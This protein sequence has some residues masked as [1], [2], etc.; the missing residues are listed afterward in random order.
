MISASTARV[1]LYGSKKNQEFLKKLAKKAGVSQSKVMDSLLTQLRLGH[2][3]VQLGVI[4]R[5]SK[6]TKNIK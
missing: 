2:M 3:E 6:L 5:P 4:S 1:C